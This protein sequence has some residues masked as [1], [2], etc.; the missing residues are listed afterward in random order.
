MSTEKIP[1]LQEHIESLQVR[2]EELQS[3]YQNQL[4]LITAIEK[5]RADI[6]ARTFTKA[7]EVVQTLINN[8]LHAA[9]DGMQNRINGM[10][11][12]TMMAL[13]VSRLEHAVLVG[14]QTKEPK[15]K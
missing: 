12:D 13:R 6:T 10:M 8:E 14:S 11:N 2:I 7:D 15:K 5:E 9:M 1:T 3:N 4:V